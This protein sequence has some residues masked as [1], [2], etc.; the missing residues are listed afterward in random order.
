M[1]AHTHLSMCVKKHVR[2]HIYTY[3]MHIYT[4]NLFRLKQLHTHTFTHTY[5]LLICQNMYMIPG[6][7][8]LNLCAYTY[9]SKRIY[10]CIRARTYIY[11]HSLPEACTR[12]LVAPYKPHHIGLGLQNP[13]RHWH[14]RLCMYVT[15]RVCMY[16]CMYV[17][18]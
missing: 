15:M 9:T 4:Y 5:I 13:A 17:C 10:I 11:L 14:L 7:L 12:C 16:V 18:M 3:N 8:T 1:Y 2:M 6:S